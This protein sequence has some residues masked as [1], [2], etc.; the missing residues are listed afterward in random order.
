ML[1]EGLEAY[2]WRAKIVV[3]WGG[4]WSAQATDLF[5]SSHSFT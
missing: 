4:F 1:H 5:G 3:C 2:G